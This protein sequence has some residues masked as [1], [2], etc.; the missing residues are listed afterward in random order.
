MR[1]EFHTIV[2]QSDNGIIWRSLTNIQGFECAKND[3]GLFP[4]RLF[5]DFANFDNR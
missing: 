3:A 2:I 1:G 4:T 5:N